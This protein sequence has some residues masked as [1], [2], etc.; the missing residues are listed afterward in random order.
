[1]NILNLFHSIKETEKK[2]DFK[3]VIEERLEF[4]ELSWLSGYDT[5]LS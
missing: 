5:E 3:F 1:M 4:E 2:K